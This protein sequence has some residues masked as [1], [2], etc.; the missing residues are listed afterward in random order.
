MNFTIHADAEIPDVVIEHSSLDWKNAPWPHIRGDVARA[1]DGWSPHPNASP[2][3]VEAELSSLLQPVITKH[4]KMR[5]PSKKRARPWWTPACGAA[6]KYK[7]RAFKSRKSHPSRLKNATK[8]C[9]RIQSK[10]KKEYNSKLAARLGSM[11]KSDKNFWNL[12]KEIAG[13]Q[14]THS[15]SAPSPEELVSHFA[16][17]MSNAADIYDNDWEQPPQRNAKTKLKGFRVSMKRVLRSLRSL[18]CSKSI[19]GVPNIFLKECATQL[20]APLTKLFRHI[21]KKGSFPERWKIGRITALHKRDAIS[22]P[23]NYRPVTVLENISLLFEDVLSDQMYAFLEKHIPPSQFGFLRKCGTQDYGALLVLKVNEI[24]ERGNECV[25]ISLDVAGAFDRVWHAGLVKKLRAAGM[26]GRALKLI[27]SYLKNRYISVFAN[28]VKSK[29][30]PIYSGVPQGGKWS[31]PLWDFEISTLQDLDLFGLLMS[32]ADDCSLLYEVTDQNRETL[33]DDINA[34]LQK[35]EDWGVLWHVSFAPDKTHSMLVSRRDKPFD[36]S[37]LHFMSE[38]V[39]P[40]TEMKLVGF[41]LDSNWTF[42]PMLEHVSKKGR[43]KLGAIFRLRHHLDSANLETMYKSFVRSSLEYGNLEYL[44]AAPSHLA[45]LDKIQ[46]S[47]ERFG[48]F[49]VEPLSSR[50]EASLI[51]FLFKLL[52]GDGRGELNAYV[53]VLSEHSTTFN[54]RHDS[55]SIQIKPRVDLR[56]TT[57]QFDRSVEGQ[58]SKVWSKLPQD[59][60]RSGQDN[61][62]QSITKDCQRFLTGKKSMTSLPAPRRRS[63]KGIK[64]FKNILVATAL[65]DGNSSLNNELN[66]KL[67]YNSIVQELK[68]NGIYL[69]K[70]LSKP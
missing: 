53:P 39:G 52:D 28:G 69:N 54:S 33:I 1:V 35:L 64:D 44:S 20:A 5:A 65:S 21:C 14:N 17:K 27:K 42:G 46:A 8:R 15:K 70:T 66:V 55:S 10:A 13:L 40:V 12:T 16:K 34:D 30:H 4:V 62:W 11:N 63:K 36:I 50:R 2:D 38:P 48:G 18:D 45:R 31:A 60:L 68:G 41:I 49:Q 32:Y 51:G 19:N 9:K 61:G 29:R 57:K 22:N 47:A 37:G 23:K 43:S 26:R 7:L 3:C 24:L 56:E 58:A 67:D 59:I 25:V 6:Y